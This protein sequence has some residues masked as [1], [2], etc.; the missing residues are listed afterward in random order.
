[1]N[2]FTARDLEAAD[3][4]ALAQLDDNGAPCLSGPPRSQPDRP[5]PA[6][7]RGHAARRSSAPSADISARG[8]RR[9]HRKLFSWPAP[10]GA[11]CRARMIAAAPG[12]AR[13]Q[14]TPAV[15]GVG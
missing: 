4:L 15:M 10:G 5:D 14:L 2:V 13:W 9:A 11:C 3:L 12:R 7:D 6:N 8:Q 1:M